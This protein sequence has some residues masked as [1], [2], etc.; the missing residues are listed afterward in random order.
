MTVS[1]FFSFG[2][3]ASTIEWHSHEPENPTGQSGQRNE[4]PEGGKRLPRA[5]I[6]TESL[7]K[8]FEDIRQK[9]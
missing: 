7:F 8:T 1:V 6:P 9:R 4:S 5:D 2:W 3:S